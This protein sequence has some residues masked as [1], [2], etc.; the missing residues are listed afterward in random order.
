VNNESISVGGCFGKCPTTCIFLYKPTIWQKLNNSWSVM[1][2]FMSIQW[3]IW[4]RRY[5]FVH[6][7]RIYCYY[8]YFIILVRGIELRAL[9]MLKHR[10]YH[11]VYTQ[12]INCICVCVW[13]LSLFFFLRGGWVWYWGLNTGAPPLVPLCQPWW[14]FIIGLNNEGYKTSS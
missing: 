6:K 4:G 2:S 8:F 14:W 13:F 9:C 11:Q 10:L 7:K 1:L 3:F 12:P 5:L